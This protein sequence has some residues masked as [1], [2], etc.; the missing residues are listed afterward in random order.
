MAIYP[1]IPFEFLENIE[2]AG[3]KVTSWET[4]EDLNLSGEIAYLPVVYGYRRLTGP[5]VFATLGVTNPYYLYVVIALGEAPCSMNKL[6][7]NDIQ[8]NF[9][10]SVKTTNEF[11]QSVYSFSKYLFDPTRGMFGDLIQ[12]EVADGS[13]G[14]PWRPSV[15][16]KE[17]L[18]ASSSTPQL[19]ANSLANIGHIV[20]RFQYTASGPFKELPKI[21]CDVTGAGA[22][23]PLS[24][25]TL[26]SVKLT[27]YNLNP[28]VA[29][30]DLLT[31]RRYGRA[32]PESSIDVASYYNTFRSFNQP[33][34]YATGLSGKRLTLN[35][36][37]DTSVPTGENIR[38][39]CRQFGITLT[40]ANGK[41]FM[42][43][44]WRISYTQPPYGSRDPLL[45]GVVQTIQS[46]LATID[47]NSIVGSILET[48]PDITVRYNSVSV[49]WTDPDNNFSQSVV[50]FPDVEDASNTYLIEDQ[51]KPLSTEIDLSYITNYYQA[52]NMA[53]SILLK[54]RNQNRIRFTLVKSAHQFVVG[55]ILTL[56]TAVPARN[57]NIRIISMAMN[58][59]YTWDIEAVT[60][61]DAWY[62]PFTPGTKYTNPKVLQPGFTVTQKSVTEKPGDLTNPLPEVFTPPQP[63]ILP[64]PGT[65]ITIAGARNLVGGAYG[66]QFYVGAWINNQGTYSQFQGFNEAGDNIP[67]TNVTN[68]K[69]GYTFDYTGRYTL[70]LNLT[71]RYE[72]LG[73]QR[74]DNNDQIRMVYD[75]SNPLENTRRYGIIGPAGTIY[76]D[77]E[78][79]TTMTR[80]T[81]PTGT[82][83]ETF[84]LDQVFTGDPSRTAQITGTLA[85]W[86]WPTLIYSKKCYFMYVALREKISTDTSAIPWEFVFRVQPTA[87]ANTTASITS[88]KF[89]TYRQ[90][91]GMKYLG[92]AEINIHP[93]TV[94]LG[95]SQT[96][97]DR[98]KQAWR[99]A[100][101]NTNYPF[102]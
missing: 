42:N 94:M 89:F 13:N 58:P 36:V 31:N 62:P 7:F 23:Y 96:Y 66:D 24:S 65:E 91:T 100:N 64:P 18:G 79:D 20:I 28:A 16:I 33:V 98:A 41:W 45:D 102:G 2:E 71:F 40:Y 21:T 76:F 51:N 88:V 95:Q 73:E 38:T 48:R 85:S 68:S 17:A 50:K 35:A 60:H 30:F 39:I 27:G 78:R 47:E 59:D 92:A 67:L 4:V 10:G 90:D 14:P 52:R 56:S 19:L 74:F 25:S 1:Q 75:I 11:G 46:S 86:G 82:F 49:R 55:D 70:I 34:P 54:S 63:I 3:G 61:D 9:L 101:G 53:Q 37:I 83:S 26:S 72:Y 80:K 15:L 81:S 6:Y 43:S 69:N 84:T 77:P 12:V 22:K 44:E 8:V 29:L 99:R 57:Q 93:S 97:I 87:D 32:F 5:R